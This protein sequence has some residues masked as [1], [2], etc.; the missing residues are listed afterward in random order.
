MIKI[1]HPEKALQLFLRQRTR[2]RRDGF[3]TTGKGFDALGAHD[4][5]E[6]IKRW[7]A[8]EAFVRVD[9][10]TI[11]SKKGENLPKVVDML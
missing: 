3:N 2:E 5:A 7:N 11:V 6:E 4:M 8:Q 9:E 10:K 1:N